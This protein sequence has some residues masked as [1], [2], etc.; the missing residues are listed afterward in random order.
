[1]QAD[2]NFFEN[3]RTVAEFIAVNGFALLIAGGDYNFE[4]V[5]GPVDGYS[6]KRQGS[7]SL[8]YA[9][10]VPGTA[11]DTVLP[12]EVDVDDERTDTEPRDHL[13]ATPR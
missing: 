4:Y 1:M 8:S 12:P 10:L 11:S 5:Q 7:R 2:L 9:T 3:C 13:D 6:L